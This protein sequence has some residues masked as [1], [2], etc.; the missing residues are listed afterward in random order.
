[1]EKTLGKC[2]E[3]WMFGDLKQWFLKR[4]IFPSRGYLIMSEDIFVGHSL[5]CV[6]G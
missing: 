1:V 2:P 6:G 5:W 4:E 3:E